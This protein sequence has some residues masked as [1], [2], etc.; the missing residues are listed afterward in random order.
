[1][2]VAGE[3]VG[4]PGGKCVAEVELSGWAGSKAGDHIEWG[5]FPKA[6]RMGNE[7]SPGRFGSRWPVRASL[8]MFG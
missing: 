6:A 2:V 7:I 3:V 8:R 1:M 4:D 5:E